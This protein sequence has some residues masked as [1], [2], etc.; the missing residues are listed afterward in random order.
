MNQQLLDAF[1]AVRDSV[2]A[3]MGH[4]QIWF[5]LRGK[6]KAIEE[7]LGDMNDCRFVDFFFA[8]NIG[9]YK[10]MFIEIAC[11]FDSGGGSH[12][13]KNLKSLMRSNGLDDLA[14]KFDKQLNAYSTPFGHPFHQ[15]PAGD[16]TGIR[17]PVPRPFG[18]GRRSEA[19]QAGH[20]YSMGV[21][22]VNVRAWRLRSDSPLR[23]IR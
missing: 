8:A 10:L 13:V 19:T 7:Y 20:C 5:T 15:H 17:P 1:K 4:Y 18:R 6:G 21:V 12:S 11:L 23:V 22:D 2:N 16:S 14:E 3:S 9:H